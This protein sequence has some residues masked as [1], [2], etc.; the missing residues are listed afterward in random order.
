MSRRETSLTLARIAGYHENTASL[1]RLY[2]ESRVSRRAMTQAFQNGRL[3]KK[4]GAKCHCHECRT[5]NAA[6]VCDK[7][8]YAN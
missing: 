3:A 7:Y 8:D 2:I 4:S 5:E 1:T 6:E